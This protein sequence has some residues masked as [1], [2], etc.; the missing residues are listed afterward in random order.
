MEYLSTEVIC[1]LHIGTR[2]ADLVLYSYQIATVFLFYAIGYQS[3]HYEEKQVCQKNY[4]RHLFT[5]PQKF[6]KTDSF[7]SS[8]WGWR[9]LHSNSQNY[10][11]FLKVFNALL[12]SEQFL[13]SRDTV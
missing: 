6:F 7:K 1:I 10:L 11:S 4:L 8:G 13:Q 3:Y 2:V 12:F 9:I 5:V